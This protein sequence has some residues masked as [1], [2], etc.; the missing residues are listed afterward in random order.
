MHI[1]RHC[2]CKK[3]LVLV[4]LRTLRSRLYLRSQ[5]LSHLVSRPWH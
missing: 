4:D 2:I 1:T 3:W 5:D